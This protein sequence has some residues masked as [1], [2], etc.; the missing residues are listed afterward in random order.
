MIKY[1]S[2][3]PTYVRNN[4]ERSTLNNPYILPTVIHHLDRTQALRIEFQMFVEV[5]DVEIPVKGVKGELKFFKNH[6]KSLVDNGDGTTTEL[7]EKLAEGWTYDATKVTWATPS[8]YNAWNYL[9]IVNGKLSFAE[10][11]AGQVA[12]DYTDQAIYIDGSLISEH[13]ELEQPE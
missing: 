12:K 3:Q 1:I 5:D 4:E 11:I 13:F 8:T 10:G 6:N 2:K 7:N 9:S